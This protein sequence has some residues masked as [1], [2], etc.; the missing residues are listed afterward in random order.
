MRERAQEITIELDLPDVTLCCID[1]RLHALALRSLA[2]SCRGVRYAKVIFLTDA[3]PPSLAVPEGVEIHRIA[4][5]A[6]RNDYSKFVV[7]ELLNHVSTP[8]VLLT[9]WD[10]YVVRPDAWRREFLDC[11]YIGAVW[12]GEGERRVGNGGFSLRSRRLLAALRDDRFLLTRSEDQDIARFR[13]I[14]EHDFGV[15]F[16]SVA[17][18][19]A[20]SFETDPSPW[21]RGEPVF[22]FHGLFNLFLTEPQPEIAAF[23]EELPDDILRSQF[24]GFLL[25]NCVNY[26]QWDAAIALGGRMLE[27]D[28]D[29]AKTAEL[30]T[31][32]RTFQAAERL[33][34]SPPSLSARLR[35]LI[36]R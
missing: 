28:P 30:L 29:N 25:S 14:L 3:V 24:C 21:L 11:D 33:T 32:A 20:F 8:H 10:G 34:R 35:A 9:Q 18:A 36:R 22:G 5:I 17:L 27:A 16:A 31:A 23:G 12:P 26:K 6:S 7:K 13:P 1:T 2:R 19:Q 4:K 15:R